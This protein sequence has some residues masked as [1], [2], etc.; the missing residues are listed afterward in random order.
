MSDIREA[1]NESILSLNGFDTSVNAQDILNQWFDLIEQSKDDIIRL[2]EIDEKNDNGYLLDFSIIDSIKEDV[3]SIDDQYKKV[4][5]MQK[6]SANVF[7]LGK[8]Q[9]NLGIIGLIFDGNPYAMIEL[10][11]KCVLTHNALIIAQNEEYMKATNEIFIKLLQKVLKNFNVSEH[12]VQNVF[13]GDFSDLLMNSVCISK[14]FVVGDK[15]FQNSVVINSKIPVQTIGYGHHDLY[16][17]DDTNLETIEKILNNSRNIDLYVKDGI[18]IDGK[19][20]IMVQDLDDAIFLMNSTG[21]DYSASIFTSSGENGSRFLSEVKSNYVSVNSSPF[22]ERYDLID[23]KDLVKIK[24]AY[25]PLS[26]NSD[27]KLEF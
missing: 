20:T 24:T 21:S 18:E 8:E 27:L 10:I 11:S 13:V 23:V 15:D 17:E 25:Y 7:V 6:D 16:I 1:L 3:L 4:V 5:S 12:F 14:V 2:S 19:D 9:D 22:I 26:F